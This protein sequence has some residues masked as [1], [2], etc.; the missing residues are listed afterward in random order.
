MALTPC[1]GCE[2]PVAQS[3]KTCP[4]CGAKDPTIGKVGYGCFQ[5]VIWAVALVVGWFVWSNCDAG[6]FLDGLSSDEPEVSTTRRPTTTTRVTITRPP[7][8]TRATTTTTLSEAEITQLAFDVLLTA[9]SVLGNYDLDWLY[10]VADAACDELDLGTSYEVLALTIF[11]ISPAD[12]DAETVGYL[13]GAAIS[14]RC[15]EYD[16]IVEQAAETWG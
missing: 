13:L 12:W 3:A 14:A 1:R 4:Q 2:N 16:W 9:H 5:V 6:S 10:E 8:T 11:N 7:I 15:D